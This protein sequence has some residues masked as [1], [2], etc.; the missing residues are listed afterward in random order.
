M[1]AE[2]DMDMGTSS[3]RMNIDNENVID[4]SSGSTAGN[5]KGS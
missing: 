1:D 3:G 5:E 2:N 4:T